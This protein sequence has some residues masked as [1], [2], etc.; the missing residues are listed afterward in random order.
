MDNNTSGL[1]AFAEELKSIL[2]QKLTEN[3]FFKSEII[4]KDDEIKLTGNETVNIPGI[5]IEKS[6]AISSDPNMEIYKT[7]VKE[8]GLAK[9]HKKG[10]IYDVSPIKKSDREI[11]FADKKNTITEMLVTDWSNIFSAIIKQ[12]LEGIFKLDGMKDS[13]YDQSS[14]VLDDNMMIQFLGDKYMAIEYIVCHSNVVCKLIDSDKLV[15]QSEPYYDGKRIIV[16][17][18]FNAD[19]TGVYP[20]YFL[21]KGAFVYNEDLNLFNIKCEEC[22]NK[23]ISSRAFV[24]HPLGFNWKKTNEKSADCAN[25]QIEFELVSNRKDVKIALLKARIG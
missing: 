10:I 6:D 13:F 1:N 20:I 18:A 12:S 14:N 7:K 22:E 3:D 11:F 4:K 8:N 2:Q 16:N 5:K 19:E 17:D 15:H 21:G 9:V 24:L 25:G 23:I